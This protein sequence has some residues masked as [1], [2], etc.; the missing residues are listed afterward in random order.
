MNDTRLNLLTAIFAV[1]AL[2]LVPLTASAQD[3]IIRAQPDEIDLAYDELEGYDERQQDFAPVTFEAG[4]AMPDTQAIANLEQPTLSGL[5][6]TARQVAIIEVTS[7]SVVLDNQCNVF[8]GAEFAVSET[9]AGGTVPPHEQR[10]GRVDRL[11]DAECDLV[12]TTR[13]VQP[14]FV[15]GERLI[16]FH[17]SDWGDVV[18]P[19]SMLDDVRAQLR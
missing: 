4:Q 7:S 17:S 11:S 19:V 1:A 14:Y 13:D 9:L 16:L 5:I 3:D 15:E 18:L 8:F 6:D 10:L 2:S 12:R